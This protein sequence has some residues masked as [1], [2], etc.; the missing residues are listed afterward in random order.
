MF[1]VVGADDVLGHDHAPGI[2]HQVGGAED[3]VDRFAYWAYVEDG[4]VTFDVLRASGA[5][6]V[7]EPEDRPWGERVAGVR[8][9]AGNLVHVGAPTA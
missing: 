7:A 3:E 9:P 8:D 5:P 2:D 4:D 6:S 1:L